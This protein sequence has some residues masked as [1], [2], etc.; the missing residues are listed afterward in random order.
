MLES[1]ASPAA[2]RSVLEQDTKPQIAP[3]KDDLAWQPLP[4]V[5]ECVCEWVNVTSIVVN[6]VYVVESLICIMYIQWLV[7]L[8]QLLCCCQRR[9]VRHV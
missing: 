1:K 6:A 9:R 8:A 7:Y 2:C 4:S 5:Y 3:D